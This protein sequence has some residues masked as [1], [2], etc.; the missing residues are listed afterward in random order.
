MEILRTCRICGK[1]AV[2]MKCLELFVKDKTSKH[3]RANCCLECRRTEYTSYDSNN[4]EERA[5]KGVANY[6]KYGW[7]RNCKN[8]YGITVEDYNSMFDHQKGMCAICGVHQSHLS[9]R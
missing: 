7:A 6:H 5:S 8:K 1:E 4:R 9:E 3:G 2:S